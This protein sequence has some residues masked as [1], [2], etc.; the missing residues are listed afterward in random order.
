[1]TTASDAAGQRCLKGV[2]DPVPDENAVDSRPRKKREW[3]ALIVGYPRQ[4]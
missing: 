1:M 3:Q 4:R 2:A